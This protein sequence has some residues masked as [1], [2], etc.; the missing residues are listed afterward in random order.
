MCVTVS[1]KLTRQTPFIQC[2][3]KLAE[4]PAYDHRTDTLFWLDIEQKRVYWCTFSVEEKAS[5]T[6]YRYVTV[7]ESVTVLALTTTPGVFVVG[8]KC[9][10]ARLDLRAQME[11][12]EGTDLAGSAVLE[13]VAVVHKEKNQKLR[14]NDGYVDS[15]GRFFAGTMVE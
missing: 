2:N 14:F 11:K 12:A 10:Y 5:R 7:A 8:A 3:C 1:C 15:K 6:D 4:G 13:Y 9:G